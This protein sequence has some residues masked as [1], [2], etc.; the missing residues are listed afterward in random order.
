M[1]QTYERA[2]IE[3]WLL[4]NHTS[5]VTGVRLPHK[6]L[7]P[8][9]ALRKVI[10]EYA[11]RGIAAEA[12]AHKLEKEI[13]KLR[14]RLDAALKVAEARRSQNLDTWALE[15]AEKLKEK[16][17]TIDS[18]A[19]RD[20]ALRRKFFAN[21][22]DLKSADNKALCRLRS[23]E[24]C[25]PHF[26]SSGPAGSGVGRARFAHPSSRKIRARSMEPARA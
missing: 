5:P 1:L 12:R 23:V 18:T 19:R 24:G 6:L 3:R 11:E 10:E 9:F 26:S 8:N 15:Q 14:Q 7:T 22:K 16:P 17:S 2:A 21:Q 25:T 4:S 13:S 20:A